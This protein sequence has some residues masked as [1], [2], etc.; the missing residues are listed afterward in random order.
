MNTLFISTLNASKN[1]ALLCGGISQIQKLA[2]AL[3]EPSLQVA[4]ATSREFEALLYQGSLQPHSP[5]NTEA[6]A[7]ALQ[8]SQQEDQGFL[9]TINQELQQKINTPEPEI[10]NRLNSLNIERTQ[11]GRPPLNF[12]SIN[13]DVEKIMNDPSLDDKKKKEAVEDL[14]KRLGLSKKDMKKLFTKRLARLHSEAAQKIQARLKEFERKALDAEKI[15][16]KDSP[17]AIAAHHRL[18]NARNNLKSELEKQQHISS[19]CKS[20][21][22]S[23]WGK[24]GGFFKKV[25]HVFKNIAQVISKVM[26][27]ISP[28]LN[29]IPGIGQAIHL[30]WTALKGFGKLIQGKVS[31]L[32]DI[33]LNTFRSCFP[34]FF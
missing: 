18:E 7:P 13:Q 11:H 16:G 29:F 2:T 26:N 20:F 22:P 30:G 1:L 19:L 17:Q 25:G 24:I 28:V 14:R 12:S 10:Q 8:N 9:N 3:P 32:L 21:Y 34:Q 27:F 5:N 23:F 31:G 4:W 15:Y 6:I 33:G